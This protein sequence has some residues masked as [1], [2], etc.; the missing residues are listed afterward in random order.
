MS[1]MPLLDINFLLIEVL[2]ERKCFVRVQMTPRRVY[3]VLT[4]FNDLNFFRLAVFRLTYKAGNI[5]V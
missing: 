2:Y 1:E 4:C 5:T 3:H